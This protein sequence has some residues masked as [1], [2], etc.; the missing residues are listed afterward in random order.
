MKVMAE[1]DFRAADNSHIPQLQG[2]LREGN[3]KGSM[4]RDFFRK[5]QNY[6][7]QYMPGTDP[8]LQLPE[9]DDFRPNISLS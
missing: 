6:Y 4:I 3:L 2:C 5:V 7:E 9:I 1:Q 8:N